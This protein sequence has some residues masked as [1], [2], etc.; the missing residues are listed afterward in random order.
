MRSYFEAVSTRYNCR[1]PS[2]SSEQQSTR[3][4][5]GA[6][7]TVDFDRLFP[8]N[9]Y[10]KELWDRL[11]GYRIDKTIGVVQI[12]PGERIRHQQ[13]MER[14]VRIDRKVEAVMKE[15]GLYET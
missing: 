11:Y 1:I 5:R 6:D 8:G 14:A 12:N 13:L 9:E 10:D 2:L 15:A 4:G 7:W 3:I